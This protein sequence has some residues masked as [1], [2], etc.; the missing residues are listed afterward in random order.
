MSL[1]DYFSLPDD[2]HTTVICCHCGELATVS[3]MN[4]DTVH[5]GEFFCTVG[6]FCVCECRGCGYTVGTQHYEAL[7]ECC[8]SSCMDEAMYIYQVED[9]YV[10]DGPITGFPGR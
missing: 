8:K 4:V 7:S 5:C 2:E 1:R 6:N 9:L 10:G 3:V